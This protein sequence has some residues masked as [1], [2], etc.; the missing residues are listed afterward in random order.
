MAGFGLTKVLNGETLS[1]FAGLASQKRPPGSVVGGSTD[2]T[3]LAA[4]LRIG[5]RTYSTAID[6]LNRA[7]SVVNLSEQTLEKLGQ[8]TGK[9][10][11]ITQRATDIATSQGT[12]TQLTAEFRDLAHEFQRTVK[13][14]TTGNNE[15]LT[16]DGLEEVFQSIGLDKKSSRSIAEIFSRFV[17]GAGD[18]SLAD[19]SIKGRD[20]A[21][22]IGAFRKRLSDS[23]LT[24]MND[25]GVGGAGEGAITRYN[26]F[27][28]GDDRLNQT[29]TG[30]DTLSSLEAGGS[31]QSIAAGLVTAAVDLV[32]VNETSGYAVIQSTDDFLGSNAGHYN[33]LYLVDSSGN[34]LHQYTTNADY[35]TSYQS[36][37]I[38]S[39]NLEIGYIANELGGVSSV[40]HAS[41]ASLGS[42]AT[43]VD[44]IDSLIGTFTGV[45]ISNSGDYLA[46]NE[47]NVLNDLHMVD[48]T[49]PGTEYVYSTYTLSGYGFAG[50]N[51]LFVLG[52]TSFIGDTHLAEISTSG[53]VGDVMP[54]TSS[55]ST[56]RV[57]EG[58][59]F[60]VYN[61][62]SNS[63]KQYSLAG[64]LE[65][66]ITLGSGDS[67]NDIS[68]ALNRAGTGIDIGVY[69]TFPSM[70]SGGKRMLRFTDNP[71]YSQRAATPRGTPS[72]YDAITEEQRTSIFDEAFSLEDRP[73][74][75]RTLSRLTALKDQID[76]NIGALK[77]AKEGLEDTISLVRDVGRAF[78]EQAGA[79]RGVE[80]A[81][82]IA[83]KLTLK[84]R[85]SSSKAL[86]QADNLNA[87][88]VAALTSG[89]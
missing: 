15:F 87:I 73:Q 21:V 55:D 68:L 57:L 78:L 49:H 22:P 60:A 67:L 44:T 18:G 89:D 43:S 7:A 46:Y 70:L 83:R 50:D 66:S 10:I 69:G 19:E 51:S 85:T 1:R 8:I 54:V 34:V 12:R 20:P 32:A 24:L 76:N 56:L 75:Y 16:A 47:S 3:S 63:V 58:S 74:A 35:S 64:S 41:F 14:A 79:I 17:T 38:S 26:L 37:D 36:A 2:S 88:T 30:I 45:K 65:R 42:A 25:S 4:G 62:P 27:F 52:D 84:I 61:S 82:D 86:A 13:N 59:G 11:D 72:Q 71:N 5:A 40:Y 77:K 39:D 48:L 53:V 9:L 28:I 23:P 81:N 29:P 33:Q 31:I 80:D 6:G